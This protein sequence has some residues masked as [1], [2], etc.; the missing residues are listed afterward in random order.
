MTDTSFETYSFKTDK[1]EDSIALGHL[2]A[3]AVKAVRESSQK[4]IMLVGANGFRD[5]GKTTVLY[6]LISAFADVTKKEYTDTQVGGQPRI[7]KTITKNEVL[8]AYDAQ[9]CRWQEPEE[10]LKESKREHGVICIEHPQL[11]DFEAHGVSLDFSFEVKKQKD[12][13]FDSPRIVSFTTSTK[14]AAHPAFQAFLK[15][16][17]KFAPNFTLA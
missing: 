11:I 7:F 3:A 1:A 9:T 14:N 16:A 2:F 15:Q 5:R 10:L 17:Q 4:P 6:G 12:Y 13:V 8:L